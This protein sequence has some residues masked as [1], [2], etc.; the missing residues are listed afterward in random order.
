MAIVAV[1][2]GWGWIPP[3][4]AGAAVGAATIAQPPPPVSASSFPEEPVGVAPTDG[5]G[6]IPNPQTPT[7]VLRLGQWGHVGHRERLAD[8]P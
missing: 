7:G 8:G 4:T 6:L 3:A 1:L 5:D 2:L